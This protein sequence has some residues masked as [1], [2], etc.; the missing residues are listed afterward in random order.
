MDNVLDIELET[1]KFSLTDYKDYDEEDGYLIPCKED[2]LKY[3]D[4]LIILFN[5]Y[6]IKL[7]NE[8]LMNNNITNIVKL[9]VL[10]F[11]VYDMYLNCFPESVSNPVIEDEDEII[12]FWIEYY[13]QELEGEYPKI[14]KIT[15]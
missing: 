2:V 13:L 5:E 14:L 9:D 7:K 3:K 12:G 8:L 15:H 1:L 10:L 11:Y 4:N 6:K